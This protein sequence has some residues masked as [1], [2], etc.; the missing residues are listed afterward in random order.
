MTI[1]TETTTKTTTTFT[2]VLCNKRFTYLL[3]LRSY[4]YVYKPVVCRVY[5]LVTVLTVDFNWLLSVVD[6]CCCCAFNVVVV[7]SV[8]V[9]VSAAFSAVARTLIRSASI[10]CPS[11]DSFIYSFIHSLVPSH[12]YSV[13]GLCFAHTGLQICLILLIRF[14]AEFINNPS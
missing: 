10:H 3:V 5:E 14:W 7:K 2:F 8:S 11:I 9:V 4:Y 13:H 12:Y 1:T 6:V